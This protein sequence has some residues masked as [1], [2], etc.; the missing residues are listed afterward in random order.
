MLTKI[1]EIRR[2]TATAIGLKRFVS[3]Q[4]KTSG[5]IDNLAYKTL[6]LVCKT[7]D[8]VPI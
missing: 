1:M 5:I 4:Y 7:E 8:L 2:N 6:A 3:I